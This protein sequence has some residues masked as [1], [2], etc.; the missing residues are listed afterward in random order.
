MTS[1]T[2]SFRIRYHLLIGYFCGTLNSY[3]ISRIPKLNPGHQPGGP[4][5]RLP[6]P[7][8]AALWWVVCTFRRLEVRKAGGATSVCLPT[9]I[10][11][12]SEWSMA[13]LKS[14]AAQWEEGPSQ[15][16]APSS[17]AE[18]Q[19][20]LPFRELF[21]RLRLQSV[22]QCSGSRLCLWLWP[23]FQE[24]LLIELSISHNECTQQGP[25]WC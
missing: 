11:W 17:Q 24:L 8:Q 19:P 22:G 18:Q 1:P 12:P 14:T 5:R 10:R 3:N 4:V 7:R 21:F 25:R 2:M 13:L 6:L 9:R 15:T 23:A 20:G 16:Q